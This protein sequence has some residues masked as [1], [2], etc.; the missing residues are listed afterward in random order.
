M[1]ATE[2]LIEEH[3]IIQRVL[4]AIEKVAQGMESGRSISPEYFIDAAS[5]IKGF[6]DG[7]HHRK[8][9]GVLFP[10]MVMNGMSIQAGPIAIMLAEHEQGRA[11]TR[12]L[13]DAA[14]QMATGDKAAR[15][16]IITNSLD[17]V[18]LLRQH[19]YKE[20]NIL[21]PM[22]DKVIPLTQQEK[23]N[24]DFDRIEKEEIGEGIHEK[25]L[26]LAAKL[27]KDAQNSSLK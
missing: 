19:I 18:N 24:Q 27:E 15:S 8:E 12:S 26:V 17:Y 7:C 13:H 3:D 4:V 16:R 20:N 11:F 14:Q 10:A 2:I 23:V 22:A 25:Y 1:K 6:A 21:F 5:F 9:E